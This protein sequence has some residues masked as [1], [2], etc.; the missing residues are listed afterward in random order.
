MSR[1]SLILEVTD[2][3]FDKDVIS[4]TQPTLVDFWADWCG[5]CK[6]LAPVV[7]QLAQTYEGKVTFKKLNI[8][9]NPATP[10]KFGVRGIP[11]LILFKNG[12]VWDQIVGVVPKAQIERALQKILI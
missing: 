2:N 1:G 4:N 9:D 11:T 8:D 10:A 12:E 6:A 3:T 5:P 7:D